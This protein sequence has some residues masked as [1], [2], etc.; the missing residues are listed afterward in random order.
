M[1]AGPDAAPRRLS[2]AKTLTCQCGQ[3]LDI[4]DFQ[5]GDQIQCP[6]CD[7][8]LTIPTAEPVVAMAAPVEDDDD[9]R[10]SAHATTE[11]YISPLKRRQQAE[12]RSRYASQA[13][14]KRV[15]IWPC[16]VLGLA[17]LGVAGLGVMWSLGP[18]AIEI[19]NEDGMDVVYANIETRQGSGE[20]ERI[21]VKPSLVPADYLSMADGSPYYTYNGA[22]P[23]WK[24]K[25]YVVLSDEGRKVLEKVAPMREMVN[26]QTGR[27][28]KDALEIVK[29]K[30]VR[31]RQS[32]FWFYEVDKANKPIRKREKLTMMAQ[33]RRGGF[34]LVEYHGLDDFRTPKGKKV[35]VA[36]YKAEAETL[37]N[38]L[39]KF[40]LSGPPMG[41]EPAFFIW[42]GLAIGLVLMA[43]GA[44]FIYESYFSKAAKAAQE[45]RKAEEAVGQAAA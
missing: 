31:L 37:T 24:N 38:P 45:K 28:N 5:P 1:R 22:A 15:M 35:Q 27:L 25:A 30:C 33:R 34:A 4:E 43:A 21:N 29:D 19:V 6:S 3:V 41:L 39:G 8:L 11:Q 20:F 14:L 9:I 2:V 18:Q 36:Y 17:S 44:F 7:A 32:G 10:T 23:W 42:S 26:P 12:R 13:R 40:E 16:L